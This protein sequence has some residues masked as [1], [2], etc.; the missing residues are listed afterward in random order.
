[1]TPLLLALAQIH[2]SRTRVRPHPP[3]GGGVRR[4]ASTAAEC[5][6]PTA[7]CNRSIGREIWTTP[8]RNVVQLRPNSGQTGPHKGHK[9]SE[10]R[11]DCGYFSSSERQEFTVQDRWTGAPLYNPTAFNPMELPPQLLLRRG[12]SDERSITEVTQGNNQ[13]PATAGMI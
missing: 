8:V 11:T 5:I 7:V 3:M 2:T 4:N 6:C 1:L 9:S 10:R 13:P 12:Q